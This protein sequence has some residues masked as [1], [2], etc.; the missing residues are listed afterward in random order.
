MKEESMDETSEPNLN[1]RLKLFELSQ[2]N[3][4]SMIKNY[5]QRKSSWEILGLSRKEVVHSKFLAWLLDPTESHQV[6]DQNLRNLLQAVLW[7][8]EKTGQPRPAWLS[9]ELETAL[10]CDNYTLANVRVTT[11]KSITNQKRI[12]LWITFDI[13]IGDAKPMPMQIVI[14]NKVASSEHGDQTTFYRDWAEKQ[15]SHGEPICLY[16]TPIPT[17]QLVE[18]YRDATASTKAKPADP[19]FV[20]INY[21]LIMDRVLLPLLEIIPGEK[22]K[23]WVKDYV[24]SLSFNSISIVTD[25]TRKDD[26]FMAISAEEKKMLTD[27]WKRYDTILTAMFA[28]LAEDEDTDPKEREVLRGMAKKQSSR[29]YT[30]YNIYY[31]GQ[32]LNETP[33]T[34]RN[35]LFMIMNK[36]C[37]EQDS[38]DEAFDAIIQYASTDLKNI[39]RP[40]TEIKDASRFHTKVFV[41][42]GVEYRISN[43][44]G[45]GNFPILLKKIDEVPCF[46][47]FTVKAAE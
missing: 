42:R 31:K 5:Y 21:Q 15:E 2:S 1:Y 43:Q 6:R 41:H 11:E 19:S 45:A 26:L 9:L 13:S 37:E 27:F 36:I 3:L 34:K 46:K 18:L 7:I 47:N 44:W 32:R 4:F 28:I 17:L 10:I 8:L 14:E 12:D 29:D 23:E 25:E 16:L 20:Y 22:E 35:V 30:K 24:R 38:R 39:I 40:L 33:E